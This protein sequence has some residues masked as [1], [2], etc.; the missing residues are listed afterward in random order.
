MGRSDKERVAGM[1]AQHGGT[2]LKS[3][4]Q[5]VTTLLVCESPAGDKYKVRLFMIGN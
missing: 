4:E 5:N 2:Y 1:V 3:L